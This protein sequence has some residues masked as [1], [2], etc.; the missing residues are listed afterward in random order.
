MDTLGPRAP[1]E[2]G[3]PERGRG[4]VDL[5]RQAILACVLLAGMLFAAGCTAGGPAAPDPLP[6]WLTSLIRQLESEPVANPPASIARYDY[7]GEIVYYLPS[8]CCDVWSTLW[9]AAG[10]VICHPDGGLT[11]LGDGNCPA[12][13]AERT[14]ELI[15]W[16]DSRR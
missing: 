14:H 1:A 7:R 13:R 3:R 5:L 15:V 12:F 4:A 6:A 11:G 8:R 2:G 16:R 9:N 10:A